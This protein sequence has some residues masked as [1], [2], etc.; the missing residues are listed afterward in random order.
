MAAAYLISESDPENRMT[1]NDA[2]L[3]I[4]K[5]RPSMNVNSG[6]IKQLE[7]WRHIGCPTSRQELEANDMYKEW[8]RGKKE[9]RQKRAGKE[10]T[11]KAVAKGRRVNERDMK[12]WRDEGKKVERAIEKLDGQ[13]GEA[14]KRNT[15]IAQRVKS[16]QLEKGKMDDPG[17]V[18]QSGSAMGY[19]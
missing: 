4:K 16:A 6:F 7:I 13:L 10:R 2:L 9:V 14:L 17:Q 3:R 15:E 19:V 8:K 18:K 11:D 12:H 1:V 5:A